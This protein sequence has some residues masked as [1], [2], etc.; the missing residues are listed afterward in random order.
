MGK[1]LGLIGGT[2]PQGTGLAIRF[3]RAGKNNDLKVVIGSRKQDKAERLAAECNERMGEHLIEGFENPIAV[4][5]SDYVLLTIPFEY[6]ESTVSGLRDKLTSDKIFV[7]VTV[8][9]TMEEYGPKKRKVPR[10]IPVEQ[11]SASE[12]LRTIV[13]KDVPVVGAFKTTS[14]HALGEIDEPLNRDVF[15]VGNEIVA[16]KEFMNVIDM[17]PDA[18]AINAGDLWYARV[19]EGMTAMVIRMNVLHKRKDL[20]YLMTLPHAGEKKW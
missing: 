10:I 7:D 3:A 5:K 16:K 13:P 8:P 12:L 1:I 6:A 15:V 9:L 14:A 2:G 11:G 4:E 20:G 18:R 19:L 17:L